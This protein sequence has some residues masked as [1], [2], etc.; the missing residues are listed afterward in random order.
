M[1]KPPNILFLST[2]EHHFRA[3]S[4]SGNPH[5]KTPHMDAL[6]ASGVSFS[7]SYSPNPVC[8]P[9]RACWFS[10]MAS[11][12]SS[13]IGN[14]NRGGPA[15]DT[16]KPTMG[17]WLTEHSDYRAVFAGKWHAG[18][19]PFRYTIDGFDVILTGVNRNAMLSD[20]SIA[21]ATEAFLRNA[22]RDRPWLMV[23]CLQ[24]PHDI[25][26]S[27]RME[28]QPLHELPYG[29]TEDDL[30]PLPDNFDYPHK[31]SVAYAGPTESTWTELNWRYYLWHYYRHVEMCDLQVGSI[32]EALRETGQLE[33]TLVIFTSDHGEG[34]ASRKLVQKSFPFD[35]SIRVPFVISQPG[36]IPAHH[37]PRTL[38]TGLDIFPTIMDYAGV[39]IPDHCRGIS[40]KPYL[41]SLATNQPAPPDRQ[42][43]VSDVHNNDIRMV[44]SD[45]YKYIACN[46][47]TELFFDMD[48]DPFEMQDLI[49]DANHAARV[50][51]H[52]DWLRAW[53]AGLD[54]HAELEPFLLPTV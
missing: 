10:G 46:D 16:G 24:Q 34:L 33:S 28:S 19:H 39:P 54:R 50:R 30:P 23:T 41:G 12:E 26:E 29:L 13:V 8:G 38:V 36:S 6:V 53:E 5:V 21:V 37:D 44:R 15:A 18:D 42:Y 32:I 51:E 22:D 35:E 1:S 52:R 25:C 14:V 11:S 9:C 7:Q 48:A 2:D 27:I 3:L 47:G 40:L 17:R 45:R 49:D 31:N 43:I 20:R 4:S